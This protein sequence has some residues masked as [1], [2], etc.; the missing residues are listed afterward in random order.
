MGVVGSK[1]EYGFMKDGR[2]PHG[3]TLEGAKKASA[4]PTVRHT[5]AEEIPRT[6]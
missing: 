3:V 6:C 1:G 5:D 4:V 2:E